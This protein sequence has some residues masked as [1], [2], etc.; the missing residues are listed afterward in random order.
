MGSFVQTHFRPQ[1]PVTGYSVQQ[2]GKSSSSDVAMGLERGRRALPQNRHLPSGPHLACPGKK[3]KVMHHKRGLLGLLLSAGQPLTLS[4]SAQ[5]ATLAL[6]GGNKMSPR[7]LGSKQ[8]C[9]LE[10]L[11]TVRSTKVVSLI[12]GQTEAERGQGLVPS[13]GCPSP[14]IA[15]A[16]PTLDLNT[17]GDEC[18]ILGI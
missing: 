6:L 4:K 17:Q 12:L 16:C 8:P 11:W 10:L 18:T 9:Q 14:F 13:L 15:P 7:N 1:K 5:E 2:G 3:V